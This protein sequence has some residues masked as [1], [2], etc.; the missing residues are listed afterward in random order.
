[1]R[2]PERDRRRDPVLACR[3]WGLGLFEGVHYT[4]RHSTTLEHTWSTLLSKTRHNVR[5]HI[6]RNTHQ[7][8][9][10]FCGTMKDLVSLGSV[11]IWIFLGGVTF[12]ETQ[13]RKKVKS[14]LRR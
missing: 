8:K 13:M 1:M 2:D 5:K 9:T 7:I 3:A 11:Y 6:T 12:F 14:N 4:R 10:S